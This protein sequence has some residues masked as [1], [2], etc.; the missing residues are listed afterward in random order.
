VSSIST[1]HGVPA[2]RSPSSY[3]AYSHS[4]SQNRR[5]YGGDLSSLSTSLAARTLRRRLNR[6]LYRWRGRN[7]NRLHAHIHN[8]RITGIAPPTCSSSPQSPSESPMACRSDAEAGPDH[9]SDHTKTTMQR[10]Q[11]VLRNTLTSKT[12]CRARLAGPMARQIYNI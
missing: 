6:R 4:F 3:R 8:A 10:T 12:H 9:P 2:S 11:I 1:S 7:C 5:D